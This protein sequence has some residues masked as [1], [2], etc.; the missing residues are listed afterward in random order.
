MTGPEGPSQTK[1]RSLLCLENRAVPWGRFPRRSAKNTQT[2]AAKCG[3]RLAVSLRRSC[4][5]NGRT[6]GGKRF[7]PGRAEKAPPPGH[8]HIFETRPK[9]SVQR[10]TPGGIPTRRTEAEGWSAHIRT[11]CLSTGGAGSGSHRLCGAGSRR[12]APGEAAAPRTRGLRG[13]PAAM[14][15]GRPGC[16]PAPLYSGHRPETAFL[17]RKRNGP[18]GSGIR[19]KWEATCTAT[20]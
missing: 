4:S 13:D 17:Y 6:P 12:P 2:A 5:A 18:A 8:P 3:G 14:S 15:E 11:G 20:P 9:A 10:R 7:L 16:P 19:R 1:R